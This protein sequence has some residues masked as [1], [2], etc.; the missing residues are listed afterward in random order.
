MP[1]YKVTIVGSV[2]YTRQ[3]FAPDPIQAEA[4]AWGEDFNISDWEYDCDSDDFVPHAI[5]RLDPND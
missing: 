5:E 4:L 3:V 2:F 1:L